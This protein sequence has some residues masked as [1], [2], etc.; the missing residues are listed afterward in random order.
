VHQNGFTLNLK[1]L[2]ILT[3]EQVE[4]VH[5]STL[6]VLWET[7]VRMDSEWALGFLERSGC[8]VDRAASRVRFPGDLVEECLRRVPSRFAVQARDAKNN[9]EFGGNM[10]HFSH[11]SG[12][13]T[14][15]LETFEPRPATRAEFI[16][17]IRVLDALPTIS[18]L[19]CYPYFGFEGAPPVMAIPEGVALAMRHSTKHQTACYTNDCELFTIQ[20]AQALGVEISGAA[21]STSPLAWG[22]EA[23]QEACRMAEAG[24]PIVTIDGCMMGGTGPATAVGSVI[25]ANAEQLALIVLVQLL[26]PGQRMLIG[27]FAG[28][29]HMASGNPAFGEIGASLNNSIW[30]QMWRHYRV[31]CGNGSPGYTSAKTIDYQAGYEK[32]MAALA[33]A[34]SGVNHLLLHFGVAAEIT[35]HPVQ[36][37]LDDD[38]AGMIGRFIAGEEVTEETLAL[39][40]IARIGPTPG[41]YLDTKHTA[42]WWREEQYLPKA[43]DRLSYGEW[44][45]RGKVSALDLARERVEQILSSHQ[46]APLTPSQEEDLARIL[47]DARKYYRQRGLL[48]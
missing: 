16:D 41:H 28:A 12:M 11:S 36:A 30:N 47:A 46:A 34:L 19:G 8:A 5:R 25:V 40:L 6:R 45:A 20:M 3:E 7:G 4:E 9:L 1:P 29:I 2:E 10:L 26:R 39:D 24:L 48:A 43:A 35:A 33:S 17:C 42:R 37:V 38:V 27:H 23:I 22:A 21:T 13:H 18:C 14:V 44:M 15:D 31:P 32:S